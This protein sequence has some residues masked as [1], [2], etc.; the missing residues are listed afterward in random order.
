MTSVVPLLKS[1]ND[2][3]ALLTEYRTRLISD[4]VTG[5]VDVRGVVVPDYEAAGYGD[6]EDIEEAEETE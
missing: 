6:V 5:K 2:E 3:I 1:L 4:I